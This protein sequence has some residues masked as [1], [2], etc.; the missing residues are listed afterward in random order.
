METLLPRN[1]MKLFTALTTF[2]L[3]AA[4]VQ[5]DTVKGALCELSRHDHTIA[6][7]D[8]PCDFSQYQGNV[9]V[10]SKRWTFA[11]PASQQGETYQRQNSMDFVRFTREGLY[12]LTVYQSG[13]KPN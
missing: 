7:V 2:T 1:I 8:F 4:P 5:A 6:V 10:T 13:K 3:V 9:Y 11:F 12:T